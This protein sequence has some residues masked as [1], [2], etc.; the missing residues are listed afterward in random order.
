M[1]EGEQQ[2][3]DLHP[4]E[5]THSQSGALVVVVVRMVEIVLMLVV[6]MVENAVV[7]AIRAADL[8]EILFLL[9]VR[10]MSELSTV[11]PYHHRSQ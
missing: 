3:E 11:S 2:V 5:S 10:R 8:C 7:A 1:V 9:Q 6:R 4:R